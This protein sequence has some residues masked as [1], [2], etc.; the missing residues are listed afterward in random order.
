MPKGAISL[1]KHQPYCISLVFGELFHGPL[2]LAKHFLLEMAPFLAK[3]EVERIL[4]RLRLM[5]GFEIAILPLSGSELLLSSVS[6][7]VV[8][9]G[10]DRNPAQKAESVAGSFKF[11]VGAER[12]QESF[13][14]EIIDSTGIGNDVANDISQSLPVLKPDLIQQYAKS[15]SVKS[16]RSRFLGGT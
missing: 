2:D 15:A 3:Q 7:V 10:I 11:S 1:S 5:A 14:E 12:L 13:L 4:L 8:D 6:P 16:F 9:R